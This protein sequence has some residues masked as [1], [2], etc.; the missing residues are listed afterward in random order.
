[1]IIC[2]KSAAS[3]DTAQEINLRVQE[4]LPDWVQSPCELTF[5]YTV[6]AEGRFHLL[7][8]T[9]V[10]QFTIC[11]QRCLE[12]VNYPFRHTNELAVCANDDIAQQLTADYDCVLG[13]GGEL[14]LLEL[15]TDELML[16]SPE[17]PHS[18]DDCSLDL[19]RFN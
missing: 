11:C 6:K 10:G 1:M 7:H 15:L 9:A 16:Y 13:K 4:R 14:D 19:A 2:L 8:Y 3:F 5:S 12:L 17:V 18:L